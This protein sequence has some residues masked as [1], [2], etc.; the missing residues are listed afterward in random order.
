MSIHQAMD[1][2][3]IP[4]TGKDEDTLTTDLITNLK[5]MGFDASHDTDYGGHGDIVIEGIP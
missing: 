2:V 5:A 4:R 3:S 1:I